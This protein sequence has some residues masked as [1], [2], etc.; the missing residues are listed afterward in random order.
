MRRERSP[1]ELA[2]ETYYNSNDADRFFEEVCGGEDIHV[3]LYGHSAGSTNIALAGHKAVVAMADKLSPVQP[4]A[5]IV[6]LGAGY[7]GGARYLARRF[8]CNVLCVNISE[9]QNERNRRLNRARDL[10]ERIDV[11]HGSFEDIPAATAAADVVWSQGAFMHSARR[12]QLLDEIDR[13]LKPGGQL[14]FSDQMQADDSPPE[15]LRPLYERFKVESLASP[16]WYRR[17]FARKGFRQ[18][19]WSDLS[20]E[21]LTHYTAVRASLRQRYEKLS[22]NVSISYM[23][24]ML[25]TLNN[26]ISAAHGGYLR[27]GIFHFDKPRAA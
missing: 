22:R 26:W 24:R 18:A 27:C 25:V 23:D 9:V 21:L 12:H 13:V 3:G 11:V 4:D 6:D 15:L 7:G 10:H 16:S 20:P 5:R 2:A 17:E 1:A 19:E 8:D 14:L